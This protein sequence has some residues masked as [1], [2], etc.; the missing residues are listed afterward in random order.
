MANGEGG[1]PVGSPDCEEICRSP[2]HYD[3]R[4]TGNS[5]I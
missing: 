2:D 3:W 5:I 4:V 1:M